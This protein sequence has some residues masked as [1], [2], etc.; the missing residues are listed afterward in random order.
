MRKRCYDEGMIRL[1]VLFALLAL[2]AGCE[3][4]GTL[5]GAGAGCGCGCN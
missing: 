5:G 1:V 2:T 4:V 3:S